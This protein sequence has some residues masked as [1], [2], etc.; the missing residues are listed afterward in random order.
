MIGLIDCNNFYVSCERVFNPGL[1]GKPVVV[2]SNNDG[3]AI[4]RS[5]EA[6][7]LGIKMGTPAFMIDTLIQQHDIKVFSS[8]YALYGDMS[9]RVMQVIREYVPHTEV[10]SIDEVFADLT[11]LRYQDLPDLART[12]RE[13]VMRCVGIPVSIGIGATKTLAKMA[14]RYAK[15]T[16]AGE[17]I[18]MAGCRSTV[19]A[20]LKHTGVDAIWGVGPQHSALLRANGFVTAADFLSAPED[21]VRKEMAVVGLR[22]QKEIKGIRCLPWEEQAPSK[23]NICT[24]RSFGTLITSKKEIRQAVATFTAACAAKLRKQGSCAGSLHVFI[25]TNPHRRQDAQYFHSITQQLEVPTSSTGELLKFAMTAIDVLYK[26]GYL[27]QKT[28]VIVQDLVP[29]ATIQLGL[30]DQVDRTKEAGVMDAIDQVNQN[31]GKDVVRYGTQ[32]FNKKWKL[33]QEHLS[34]SYTTRFHQL[35]YVKAS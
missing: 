28:G 15:K 18:F 25:Q 32:E 20:L 31:F 22:I 19:D 23:K 33:R 29:Q 7:R 24:S 27:F 14:N 30:F 3:C 17:G 13:A 1:L 35:P 21:W 6:K 2:L 34:P 9:A 26:P 10:Y 5:E 11:T 4:A 16:A 8:N 12:I